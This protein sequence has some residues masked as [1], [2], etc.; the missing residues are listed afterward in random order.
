[1]A[2]AQDIN[3][4]MK[5]MMG[6][7]PVDTKAMED[8]FKN[9]AALSEKLS[10]VA[11]EAAEKSAEISGAWTKQTLTKLSLDIAKAVGKD[12]YPEANQLLNRGF[13]LTRSK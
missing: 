11:L 8:A 1:M 7:F 6:A 10:G 13:K 9:Q 12:R 3:T 4:M 5:D 2:K